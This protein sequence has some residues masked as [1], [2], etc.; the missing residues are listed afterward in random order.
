MSRKIF[1]LVDDFSAL[2]YKLRPEWGLAGEEFL[3]IF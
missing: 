1:S 3:N 2:G